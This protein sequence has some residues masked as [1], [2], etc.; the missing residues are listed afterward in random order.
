MRISERQ[1]YIDMAGATVVIEGRRKV[2]GAVWAYHGR[3][4]DREGI[5]FGPVRWW[6][7]DGRD[8]QNDMMG[9]IIRRA[10]VGLGV[11]DDC[12]VI[13]ERLIEAIETDRALPVRVLPKMPG[14]AM[15]DVIHEESDDDSA[16]SRAQQTAIDAATERRAK[17]SRPRIGRMDEALAWLSLVNDEKERQVLIAFAT[18]RAS[19]MEWDQYI[20]R[21]NRRRTAKECWTKRTTYRIIAKSLQTIALSLC[22]SG[23]ILNDCAGLQVAHDAAKGTGKSIRSDLRSAG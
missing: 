9:H 23:I 20:Q 22:R 17:C 2:N 1:K 11:T 6:K 5:K 18:V 8:W 15:P 12:S 10:D 16:P 14:N 3:Q 13:L 21:R 7:S 19:G 4:I